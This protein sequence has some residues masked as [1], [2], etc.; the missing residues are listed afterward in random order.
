MYGSLRG[1]LICTRHTGARQIQIKRILELYPAG[2]HSGGTLPSPL[3]ECALLMATLVLKD[4]TTFTVI[5][6]TKTKYISYSEYNDDH[7]YPL[8][9]RTASLLRIG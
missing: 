5:S 4:R 9:S 1:V 8:M 2:P 6:S 3:L 7:L